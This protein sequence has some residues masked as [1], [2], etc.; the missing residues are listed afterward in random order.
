MA[1]GKKGGMFRTALFDFEWN[2]RG[3]GSGDDVK[4]MVK[5]SQRSLRRPARAKAGQHVNI[6][7]EP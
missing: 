6:G 3:L 5:R 7:E 4:D 2:V 1:V